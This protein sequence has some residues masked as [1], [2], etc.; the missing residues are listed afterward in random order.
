MNTDITYCANSK[1]CPRDYECVRALEPPIG[2]GCITYNNFHEPDGFGCEHFIK[3]ER[4]DMGLLIR[5]KRKEAKITQGS[6]AELL[7]VTRTVI[8]H[9]EL[10]NNEITISRLAD[11]AKALGYD[12]IVEFKESKDEINENK[13]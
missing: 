12:L 11:I 5:Q 8:T 2:P 4:P 3:R 9:Y 6:L 1:D 7:S 10:G 13:Q